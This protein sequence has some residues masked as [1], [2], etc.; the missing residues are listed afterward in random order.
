V[1]PKVIVN[2]IVQRRS[3]NKK[4][5]HSYCLFLFVWPFQIS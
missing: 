2:G 3:L 5:T 4:E 1:D